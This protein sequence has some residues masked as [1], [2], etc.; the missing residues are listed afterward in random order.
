MGKYNYWKGM[1]IDMMPTYKVK[2]LA[3]RK[4]GYGEYA[5][6][7]LKWEKKGKMD[8]KKKMNKKMVS[9]IKPFM[10]LP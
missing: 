7:V 3:K 10:E 5:R 1:A 2:K 8:R 4:D 9:N 6:Q